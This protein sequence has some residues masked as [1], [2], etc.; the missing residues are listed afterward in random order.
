MLFSWLK[1]ASLFVNEELVRVFGR[2]LIRPY[3]DH[4][5]SFSAYQYCIQN[6][7]ADHE[8]NIMLVNT[9]RKVPVYLLPLSCS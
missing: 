3:D 1:V 9:V 8:L 2:P 7:P 5:L 6:I 4:R